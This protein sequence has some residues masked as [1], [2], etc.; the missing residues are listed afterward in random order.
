MSMTC[1]APGDL[2]TYL[3]EVA[4]G[5]TQDCRIVAELPEGGVAAE[6]EQAADLAGDVI[7]IDVDGCRCSADRAPPV[8]LGEQDSS[9]ATVMP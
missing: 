4:G 8:L 3:F 9:S 5:S 6:A 2:G 1:P 7:V